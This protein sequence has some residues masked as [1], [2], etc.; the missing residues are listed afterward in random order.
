MDV[1]VARSPDGPPQVRVFYEHLF[2]PFPNLANL[3]FQRTGEVMDVDRIDTVGAAGRSSRQVG[4]YRFRPDHRAGA[5]A[6]AW[7]WSRRFATSIDPGGAD[8]FIAA[9][10][11]FS[12]LAVF[13]IRDGEIGSIKLAGAP[14]LSLGLWPAA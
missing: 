3:Y 12:M 6:G 1:I 14:M 4:E 10:P 7:V 5:S 13:P 9:D 8:R 11:R 2:A